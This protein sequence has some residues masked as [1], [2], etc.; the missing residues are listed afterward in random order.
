M[1]W[2]AAEAARLAA[3][4]TRASA[5]EQLCHLRLEVAS[6]KRSGEDSAQTLEHLRSTSRSVAASHAPPRVWT[7]C[8]C[9]C[10]R[11]FF[12]CV[13]VARVTQRAL[14]P[15]P[16]PQGKGGL[17]GERRRSARNSAVAEAHLRNRLATLGARAFGG[18][19]RP[20]CPPSRP[21]TPSRVR[22]CWQAAW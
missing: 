17:A 5:D 2:E 10:A 19:V 21:R 13:V 14:M 20:A 3:V 15:P 8:L 4:A 6:L 18:W 7:A 22:A 16:S 9:A 12:A 1:R 11:L